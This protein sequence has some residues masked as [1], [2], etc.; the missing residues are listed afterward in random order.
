LINRGEIEKRFDPFYYIPEIVELEK[1]VRKISK[2][3]LKDFIISM[4]SGSTPSVTEEEKFY[5]DAENGVPFIRVQ[6]L[7][8]TNELMINDLKYINQ[9]THQKYLNRSQIKEGNLL[10]KITGVGRMAVS[11]I[12]PKEFEGNINQHLVVIKT[13]DNFTS[14]VLATFLNTDIAEKLASKRATGGTRPALDY[15]ALKSMP[16]V[17]KPEIV[18]VVK[19]VIAVKNKKEAE[20]A[21]LL[22]SIDSYLLQELGITLPPP[23]EKKTCFYRNFSKV[24]GGRLDPYCHKSEFEELEQSLEIGTYPIKS[25]KKLAKKITSGTTP[26]SGGDD[27]T[28]RDLGIPF[29]RSGEINEFDEIDFDDVIYIKPSVHN[30]T[31][32]SSQLKK[33]DLMIAIVGAT[34]GQV[35]VFKY[36]FEAN[37]NQAIALI[38]F[39][40]SVNVEFVKS[41]LKTT[42]GQKVLDKLKRPVAR[43]N[44]NLEEISSIK[45]P[46]PTLK[47]QTEIANHISALRTQAKQLQQQAAAELAHA[48]Q[49]VEHLILGE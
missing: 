29:I 42:I 19:Q 1:R 26:T 37:I 13:K 43:A 33:N 28:S 39:D 8:P 17:F 5:S 9:E 22:A 2:K 4:A 16:I 14:E 35:G 47:K 15:A 41:F 18:E 12:V 38:R 25:F 11:S 44:I 21:A 30:K 24:S 46:L 10:I 23:S 6:N 40:D 3:R 34:I 7:S 36:E 49:H 27:Y 48:K 32:K 45:I 20:A 31:L